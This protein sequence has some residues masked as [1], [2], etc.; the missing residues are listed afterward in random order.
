MTRVYKCLIWF[1]MLTKRL[2][3]QWSFII[4]LCLIPCSMLLVNLALSHESGVVHVALCAEDGDKTSAEIIDSLTHSSSIIQF[5]VCQTPEEATSLVSGYEADAAWIFTE[6]FSEKTDDYARDGFAQEPFINIIQREQSIPLKIAQEKLFGAIYKRISFSLYMDFVRTELIDGTNI[7]EE[8]VES[9]YE[10]MQK[11]DDIIKIEHLNASAQ[12]RDATYLTAPL[13]GIMSLLV[14]LCTLAAGMYFLKEQSQGKF[15]WLS[16]RKRIIPALA[17]CFSA[18]CLSAIAV[19][20]TIYCAGVS[21][22][23]GNELLA[24]FLFIIS[25][26][27]FCT[28]L[29]TFFRSAGKFG[30]LIP[31]IIIVMLALSPIFFN[32]KVLR[33]IRLML[34]TYYYLQSIYMPKYFVYTLIYCAVTYCLGFTLNF[35]IAERKSGDSIL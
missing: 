28:T 5:S 26:T 20:I 16:A 31:G 21:S 13:R 34:P 33:H 15:A 12:K 35:F 30:A 18:A 25:V 27:G 3:R 24:M 9:Y 11:G 7:S 4:L 17:S 8:T 10:S 23:F 1:Y 29:L 6:D 32:V 22:T 2:L 19:F 14:V